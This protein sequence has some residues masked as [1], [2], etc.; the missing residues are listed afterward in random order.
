VLLAQSI[1]N[2]H[3]ISRRLVQQSAIQEA[4]RRVVTLAEVYKLRS[5]VDLLWP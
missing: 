4:E 5:D 3:Y 2:Y 1:A